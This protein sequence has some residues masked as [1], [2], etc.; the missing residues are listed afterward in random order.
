MK[1]TTKNY[2]I[3]I[4]IYLFALSTSAQTNVSGGI[5][6]NAV[7]TLANSPYI[8]TSD[9]VVFPG[10]RL[11]IEPGVVIKFE[12]NTRLEIRQATLLAEGTLTDSITFTSN[13]N[14]PFAGIWSRV[15]INYDSN[16]ATGIKSIF[17]YC[18]FEYSDNAIDI[19]TSVGMA[20]SIVI[21]KSSFHDNNN[22]IKL[23]NFGVLLKIEYC[24]ITNNV[25]GIYSPGYNALTYIKKSNISYN[26]NGVYLH[27][28]C[29][30]D[31][32]LVSNNSADGINMQA[33]TN[34]ITNCEIVFNG[35]GIHKVSQYNGANKVFD[36]IIEDNNIGIKMEQC[37]GLDSIKCNRICNNSTYDFFYNVTF[38]NNISIEN[39]YWCILDSALIA[40][41]I[42]D[43]YDDI[44]Y[45][46]VD[47]MPF[48]TAQCS[49]LLATDVI[50]SFKNISFKAFPNP[51]VNYLEIE[52]TNNIGSAEVMIFN[53]TGHQEMFLKTDL[54]KI[55]IDVSALPTGIHFIEVISNKG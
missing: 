12:N 4:F 9:V 49:T 17:R 40:A 10:V 38:N 25:N 35:I 45:S 31:S 47:F 14:S 2:L 20:D 6:S 22:A 15:F 44:D 13:S 39:N 26:Q 23:Y 51:M 21:N 27:S 42:Y 18:N 28:N 19:T 8:V 1:H 3:L 32:C 50:E 43:G 52:L 5:Y 30:I 16:V 53:I 29:T 7:W 24:N 55:V 37:Y 34:K 54:T 33:Y 41:K 48:D 46:L 11:T 36:N